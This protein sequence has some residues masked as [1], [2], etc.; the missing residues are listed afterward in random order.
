MNQKV[1][2]FVTRLN[3]VLIDFL[4]KSRKITGFWDC[5]EIMDEG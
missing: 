1:I 5:A 3:H 2:G 4:Q